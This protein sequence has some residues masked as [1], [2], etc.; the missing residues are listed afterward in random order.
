MELHQGRIV[1]SPKP[2]PF[3][4]LVPRA[5]PL[6]N[7]RSRKSTWHRLVTCPL[8]HSKILDVINQRCGKC[9]LPAHH[10]FLGKSPREEI[11]LLYFLPYQDKY[12]FSWLNSL[13]P[14]VNPSSFTQLCPGKA[15]AAF[16]SGASLHSQVLPG[17][18]RFNRVHRAL[19]P[20]VS[21]SVIAQSLRAS[22]FCA[23]FAFR[24]TWSQRVSRPF[25]SD[26]SSTC[27]DREDLGK[28][29]IGMRQRLS[30]KAWVTVSQIFF[31]KK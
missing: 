2:S 19:H 17:V 13:I 18:R 6:E 15:R 29:L 12:L 9:E 31:L 11:D 5:L 7:G 21:P 24:V 8:V 16:S 22:L 28:R 14:I 23:G 26:T 10:I 3:Y 30:Q 25:A 1:L 4:N 20:G 27:I